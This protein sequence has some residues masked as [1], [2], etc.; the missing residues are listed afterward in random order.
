[1]E[2]KLKKKPK[3][4]KL[5]EGF[6]GFGLVGTIATEFLMDH[7]ETEM[8]GKIIFDEAQPVVAIHNKEL[9]EPFGIYYNKKHNLVILHA[10]GAA[11]DH[12]WKIA[13]ALLEVVKKLNIKEIISL[14]GVGNPKKKD[15]SRVFHYTTND[16]EKLNE[17]DPLKEGIIMGV[18]GALL[19][20]SEIPIT[21]FF[22]ET[23]SKLP[24]SKAAAKS[25]EALDKYLGLDIETKPLLKQAAEFEEKIQSIYK[26]SQSAQEEN[27]AKKLSYLG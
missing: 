26:Q 10:I 19:V 27:E 14:E 23:H 8:I 5:V 2:I 18:T 24:D 7:L 9:V 21:C 11:K 25:I 17:I 15:K 4:A 16:T 1:M 13:D 12:E 6:P 20:K 22:A 3:N